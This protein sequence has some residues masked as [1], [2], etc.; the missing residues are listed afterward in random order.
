MHPLPAGMQAASSGPCGRRRMRCGVGGTTWRPECTGAP[1]SPG[2]RGTLSHGQAL[3]DPTFCAC[4]RRGLRRQRQRPRRPGRIGPHAARSLPR[5]PLRR[6]AALPGRAHQGHARRASADACRPRPHRARTA[7][8]GGRPRDRRAH[9][10]QGRGGH[11]QRH[12]LG[13]GCP[14]AQDRAPRRR[15]PARA[16]LAGLPAPAAAPERQ[17]RGAAGQGRPARA[18]VAIGCAH[19]LD[20]R[21]GTAERRRLFQRG[22]AG[23]AHLGRHSPGARLPRE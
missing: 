21:L 7:G 17:R 10:L 12:H 2:D 4:F 8:R 9:R 5:R 6:H 20:A 13:A 22:F 15:A 23:P 18:G 14:V 19:R 11:L 16:Q 3:P 1:T